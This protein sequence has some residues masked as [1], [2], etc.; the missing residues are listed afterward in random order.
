MTNTT[1]QPEGVVISGG[2][3]TSPTTQDLTHQLE[4]KI[5]LAGKTIKNVAIT[6]MMRAKV[7]MEKQFVV[8]VKVLEGSSARLH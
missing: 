5:T 3:V 4:K 2:L 6:Q 1:N 7:K 8:V